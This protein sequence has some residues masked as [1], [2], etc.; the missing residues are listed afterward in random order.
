M[1]SK[2]PEKSLQREAN[3]K[4]NCSDTSTAKE[5]HRKL[6]RPATKTK[7]MPFFILNS[8]TPIQLRSKELS[9]GFYTKLSYPS[10]RISVK[11]SVTVFHRSSF[12]RCKLNK[13]SISRC[14]FQI[15]YGNVKIVQNERIKR[16]TVIDNDEDD[17][18]WSCVCQLFPVLNLIFTASN[19]EFHLI[20]CW[21]IFQSRKY[22]L[23]DKKPCAFAN[24]RI[25]NCFFQVPLQSLFEI[26]FKLI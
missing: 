8:A 11:W 24:F 17:W 2:N 14:T 21:S 4:V 22:C 23:I 3:S 10:K 15:F 9:G 18:L 1:K 19:L 20:L 25:N 12:Y 26:L 7:R 13:G 16:R 5:T 6:L